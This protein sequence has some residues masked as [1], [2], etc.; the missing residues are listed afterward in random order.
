MYRLLCFYKPSCDY[1]K[2]PYCMIET[3]NDKIIAGY[4]WEYINRTPTSS[5][6]VT[7]FQMSE[8]LRNWARFLAW[9]LEGQAWSNP[10]SVNHGIYSGDTLPLQ[11]YLNFPK[12]IYEVLGAT[13]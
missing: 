10:P 6:K 13:L 1:T 2:A 8:L 11:I 9:F 3:D 5:P 4:E 12:K 7:L